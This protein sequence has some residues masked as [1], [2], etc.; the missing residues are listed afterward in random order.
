MTQPVRAVTVVPVST[1]GDLKYLTGQV[2]AFRPHIDFSRGN[3][4]VV[5]SV[6]M[7]TFAVVGSSALNVADGN[8]IITLDLHSIVNTKFPVSDQMLQLKWKFIQKNTD[9]V[10]HFSFREATPQ[11]LGILRSAVSLGKAKVEG[12]LNLSRCSLFGKIG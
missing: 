1:I 7:D 6:A 5:N 4:F 10:S 8:I 11:E 9:N 2:I 3:E 12:A